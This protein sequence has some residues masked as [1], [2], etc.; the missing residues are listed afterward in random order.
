[1]GSM[2]YSEQLNEAERVLWKIFNIIQIA[3]KN[4][5]IEEIGQIVTDY[6]NAK[7]NDKEKERG[8]NK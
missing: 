8:D 6:L 2:K 5:T 7:I 1:M 3:R 4:K